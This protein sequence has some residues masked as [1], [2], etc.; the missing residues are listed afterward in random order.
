MASLRFD[1]VSIP[2]TKVVEVA[3]QLFPGQQVAG[4]YQ[5]IWT[6]GVLALQFRFFGGLEGVVKIQDLVPGFISRRKSLPH[7]ARANGLTHC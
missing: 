2:V 4:N 1:N 7:G 3:G 5:L 6:D